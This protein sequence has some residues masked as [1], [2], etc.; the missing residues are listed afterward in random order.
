[1]IIQ[2]RLQLPFN[3]SDGYG[4]PKPSMLMRKKQ[5]NTI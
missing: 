2:E 1:M 5:L 4:F 3:S